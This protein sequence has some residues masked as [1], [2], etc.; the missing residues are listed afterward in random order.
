MYDPLSQW[1]GFESRVFIFQST[2]C[3]VTQPH[4]TLG[5]GVMVRCRFMKCPHEE[6]GSSLRFMEFSNEWIPP[7]TK[8]VILWGGHSC[9]SGSE[10]PGFPFLS[11]FYLRG[12]L[13][14]LQEGLLVKVERAVCDASSLDIFLGET[15]GTWNCSACPGDVEQLL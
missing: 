13:R 6:M 8:F 10:G 9:G 7:D 15:E 5:A 14:F 4:E 1:G 12:L 11:L 2:G 3:A